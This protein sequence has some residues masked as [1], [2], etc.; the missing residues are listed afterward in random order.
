MSPRRRRPCGWSRM[1]PW[2]TPFR[3]PRQAAGGVVDTPDSAVS[4]ATSS[5]R[6]FSTSF[7]CLR[8]AANRTLPPGPH[9]GPESRSEVHMTDQR[10]I[11]MFDAI[12]DAAPDSVT[13]APCLLG[14]K[15]I[16]DGPS[17]ERVGPYTR[18]VVSR[19]RVAE[20]DDARVAAEYAKAGAR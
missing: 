10:E 13:Y 14:G 15:W 18:A 20:P 1:A 12:L 11:H 4:A 5:A 6:N 16:G 2:L 17:A 8:P 9:S 19:A 3:L 7:S